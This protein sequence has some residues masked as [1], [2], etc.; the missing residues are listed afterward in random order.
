MDEFKKDIPESQSFRENDIVKENEIVKENITAKENV[1]AKEYVDPNKNSKEQFEN[2][3]INQSKKKK[4]LAI[5]T[6]SLTAVVAGVVLGMTNYLNVRMTA[7]FSNFAYADSTVSCEIKVDGLTEKESINVYV[8]EENTLVQD[9]KTILKLEDFIGGTAYFT[10]TVDPEHIAELLKTDPDKSIAYRFDLKGIVGLD[11]ERAFDSYVLRIDSVSSV[12]HGVDCWC[13][14]GIDHCYN[15]KM[16]FEDDYN[17]FY[18]FEAYIEDSFGNVSECLWETD[19]H[20]TQKINVLEL[21]GSKATLYISYSVEGT[22]E[23]VEIVQDI[24]L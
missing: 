21:V 19:L 20:E 14:C 12:F 5:M 6:G 15:F 4:T 10:Y 24:N 22:Q 1:E 18:D 9:G 16:N 11:V 8:Y 23:R 13:T 17:I 2:S 3:R 7:N